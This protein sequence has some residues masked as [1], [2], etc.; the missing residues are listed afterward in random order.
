MGN[1]FDFSAMKSGV[2][3]Q[4]NAH[5]AMLADGYPQALVEDTL[6]S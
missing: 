3:S 1:G 2:E 5:N 6:S 4:A